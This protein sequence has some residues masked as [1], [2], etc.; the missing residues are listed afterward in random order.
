MMKRLLC[1]SV[2]LLLGWLVLTFPAISMAQGTSAVVS[3]FVTD[4]SGA[5]LPGALV[6]YTNVATDLSGTATTNGDG[7][8]RISGLSAGTY[9]ATVASNGFKTEVKEGIDLQIEE[10]VS[11]NYTLEVGSASESVTVH[12]DSSILETQSPTVSQVIEGRQVQDTP[13][14]GRNTMNLV[15]LTPGVVAQGGTQG[16]ASNNVLGGGFTNSF[17]FGNYSIAGGLANQ[18]AVY[19]D[20][21]PM[22]TFQGNLLAF[23]VTQDSIQE[24]RV[25]SSVVNPQY[26]DFSGGVISFGTKSGSNKLHGTVYEYLRNTIFDANTFFL[27]NVHQP[28]PQ[29]IQNQFGATVGGPV[30]KDK[31]FFFI[32]YEGFRQ[33]QG[34]ANL[35][36]VPTPAELGGDFTADPKV[37]NPVPVLGPMIAPGVYASATYKQAQCGGVLNKFC[38]GAPVNPGDAVADPTAVYLAN[39]LHYFPLPNTQNAGPAF[40]YSQ[41]GRAAAHTNQYTV[42]FDYSLNTKNKVFA[43]YTRFDRAQQGTQFFNNLVGPSSTT[44]VGATVN[45]YV[46]GDTVTL[47][48]TSVL[49]LRLS[50]MRFFAYLVPVNQNVNLAGLD[51][52]NPAGFWAAAASEIPPYFPAISI[53]NNVPYPYIG[54]DQYAQQPMNVY[55]LSGTFSKVLGKHL[56]SFGGEVRQQEQYFQNLPFT[57]GFFVFAGTNTSCIPS[58]TPT[59]VT[60]KDATRT[61]LSKSCS[62]P[63]VIPG[64][65]ETPIADF[66]SGQFTAAPVGFQTTDKPSTINHY[67]G[68][69]AT[70]T[71]SV[72]PRLTITAGLRYELPGGYI[73][74]HD[75]NAVILPQLANPLVLVNSSAY[76]SRSDLENHLTL[77]SPRVG[78]SFA[79]YPGTTVRA[80]YSLAYLPMD[81]VY[82]AGPYGSSVNTPTTFV[83]PSYLL[84][85]PLGLQSNGSATTTI[86]QPPQ[87]RYGNQPSLFYGQS[88]SGREPYSSFPYLQQWNANLQQAFGASAAVQLAYLGARGDHLP[89]YGSIDINQLP[90]KYVGESPSALSQSQ[91][92]Y[93]LFQ[94]VNIYSPYV[95]D[96]YYHSLQATLTKNFASGGTIL[97]NYSW[98]KFTGNSESTNAQVESHSQGVIQNYNNLRGERSYLSFDVPQHLVVS[99]ILDL[100]FG[101]GK[102]FLGATSNVVNGIVSGWDA[103]GINI[104]ESGFPLAIVSTTN[105]LSGA[106]GAGTIRPNVVPGCNKKISIGYVQAAETQRPVL[107]SACFTTPGPTSFGNQPRTDGQLRAQGVDNWDFSVGKTIPIHEALNFVFRAEAFNVTNRVQFGD[108]LLT[109]SSAAFG[110]LT[111][112]VNQP[113]SFQFSLRLNY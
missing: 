65:G 18:G 74:K 93:P 109:N 43:R 55:T 24:F 64:S 63:P 13:L 81:T 17:S 48:Q 23:V 105:A 29:Y 31:A 11:V 80:G 37:I 21:A 32:S 86:I 41:N 54:V 27:N 101:R 92:P 106:Y 73:E 88:I 35:G 28:R 15:A 19:L 38:I 83:P 30:I 67:A 110:D 39:T 78:A 5:K 68:M 6:T 82:N 25:E 12:A 47:N 98:S 69:F 7:L 95:G 2:A 91:R 50:A 61:V 107:N 46:L 49:D 10:Q 42:R 75:N 87:R 14:N 66:L 97:A 22:N 4:S 77:F 9:K 72:S 76:S 94:N 85:A 104:F 111:T 84:S 33:A 53:T 34:V 108:P 36:R 26:G 59:T 113:R 56:L 45:Q 51:N 60:F 70:D 100:P 62:G 71:F 96:S 8:Y 1:A 79:P 40:N 20:G 16:A 102:R 58:A 3:G 52:G 57:S 90:D 44:A 103:S 112:Q 89:I 99:Y